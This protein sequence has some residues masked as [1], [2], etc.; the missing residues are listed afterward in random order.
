VWVRDTYTGSLLARPVTLVDGEPHLG[1]IRLEPDHMN[2]LEVAAGFQDRMSHSVPGVVPQPEVKPNN[3]QRMLF[4]QT[5]LMLG[6]F[7]G[8]IVGTPAGPRFGNQ[9]LTIDKAMPAL[10][11][12]LATQDPAEVQTFLAFIHHERNL[13]ANTMTA[14]GF[15]APANIHFRP[16][17]ARQRA[18]AL[19][20]WLGTQSRHDRPPPDPEPTEVTTDVTYAR[21]RSFVE[22][23]LRDLGFP[24]DDRTELM[25]SLDWTASRFHP[26]PDT[27][28]AADRTTLFAGLYLNAGERL[29]FSK[30]AVVLQR[31]SGHDVP[32][33]LTLIVR[34][35]SK[36]NTAM[37]A[38]LQQLHDELAAE[39]HDELHD[40]LPA[41]SPARAAIQALLDHPGRELRPASPPLNAAI[42]VIMEHYWPTILAWMPPPE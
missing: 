42:S 41:G 9:H 13:A 28:T 29:D 20:A 23:R 7:T 11:A 32:A 8:D 1:S 30:K 4:H 40:E 39:L 3:N 2:R 37:R 5:S 15:L 27:M 34:D 36:L 12:K 14:N 26:T 24:D 19:P 6:H 38:S 33:P 10:F 31:L 17:T 35:T 18:I 22:T 25:G 16:A 21:F